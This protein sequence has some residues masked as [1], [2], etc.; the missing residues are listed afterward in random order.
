MPA[1]AI[2][3]NYETYF[4][5]CRGV[6]FV[7]TYVDKFTELGMDFSG[8][9]CPFTMWYHYS[10]SA[11]DSDLRILKGIGINQLRV[12]CN[13]W[14][15]KHYKNDFL[16]RLRD[17]AYKADK[18]RLYVMWVFFDSIGNDFTSGTKEQ[19]TRTHLASNFWVKNP[20]NAYDTSSWFL[21]NNQGEDYVSSII[22]VVS[23][24]TCTHA[25]EAMNEPADITD[26]AGFIE[27]TLSAIKKY[28]QS[29]GLRRQTSVGAGVT[30]PW[31]D[32]PAL[33]DVHN[34]F[35]SDP[36]CDYLTTHL[37][38]PMSGVWEDFVALTASAGVDN[39]KKIFFS[40]AGHPGQ[41]QHYHEVLGYLSS[42]GAGF[43]IFQAFAGTPLARD[44]HPLKVYQGIMYEDGKTRDVSA[45]NFIRNLAIQH[46]VSVEP[47]PEE[48]DTYDV[49]NDGITS[50][51]VDYLPYS[52]HPLLSATS[53][54]LQYGDRTYDLD[55]G[56]SGIRQD[57]LTY[58]ATF[59]SSLSAINSV[60]GP[61]SAI[62]NGLLRTRILEDVAASILLLIDGRYGVSG[63]QYERGYI[64]SAHEVLFNQSSSSLDNWS[65]GLFSVPYT[66]AQLHQDHLNLSAIA[67]VASAA[68]VNNGWT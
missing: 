53:P 52:G 43:S 38:T 21:T 56:G 42:I 47:M 49:D 55:Y 29:T 28:D 35:K 20:G 2:P 31:P 60:F 37:Y 50:T 40:E 11:I 33:V 26:S 51:L 4:M 39:N 6:N 44:M 54:I 57:V 7:P 58:H 10:P 8:V 45:V 18:H 25:Y 59:V 3:V 24:H 36:N 41:T 17:F 5:N 66:D 67:L 27:Y 22:S 23:G 30:V 1:I 32:L 34:K 65:A 63:T 19:D 61:T 13:F 16:S 14:Y 46:G 64:T 9:N 15:Y 62:Q 12:W 68:Y 48:P